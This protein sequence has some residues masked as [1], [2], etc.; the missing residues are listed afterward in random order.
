MESQLL[1][2]T[3]GRFIHLCEPRL[4]GGSLLFIFLIDQKLSGMSRWSEPFLQ[5]LKLVPPHSVLPEASSP[6][7]GTQNPSLVLSESRA[8]HLTD[9]TQEF[10]TRAS[11]SGVGDQMPLPSPSVNRAT[12]SDVSEMGT[13]PQVLSEQSP[14]SALSV[15]RTLTKIPQLSELLSLFP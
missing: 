4:D 14:D 12:D 3:L 8:S 9:H 7:P 6:N 15:T 1:N 5:T 2:P 10:V 13:F 11:P